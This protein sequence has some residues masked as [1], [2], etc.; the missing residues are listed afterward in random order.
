MGNFLYP[1]RSNSSNMITEKIAQELLEALDVLEQEEQTSF[2]IAL[3]EDFDLT[4]DVTS[5]I[6]ST[7]KKFGY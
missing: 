1:D 2:I 5:S 6:L 4:L 7:L 3:F